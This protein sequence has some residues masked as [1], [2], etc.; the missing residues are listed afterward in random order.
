[1]QSLAWLD[2][3]PALKGLAANHRRDLEEKARI[4][5]LPAG[6]T[7]FSPGIKPE[8]FLLVR[9]GTVRV[10][11]TSEKGR[12]I[13]LYRIAAGES[14]VLTTACLLA[15]EAYQATALAETD[16]E[17]VA[18]PRRTFEQ[19]M[20]ESAPFRKFVFESYGRR[21][22]ELLQLVEEVAFTR[23]DIKLAHR[24]I[25][26]AQGSPST[27]I[28]HQQLAA[29]LGT[30]REVIGRQLH[31]FQRRGWVKAVRGEITILNRQALLNLSE[32]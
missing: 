2:S 5:N 20:A 4:V 28:T 26:L 3:F 32:H 19:A 25:A 14:C 10:Q 12:E 9:R 15:H 29:E 1:M 13:V 18:I 21:L 30:A 7:L 31:E 16:V 24:L 17:G 23:L 22:T 27:K 6:A 11:Q 8:F